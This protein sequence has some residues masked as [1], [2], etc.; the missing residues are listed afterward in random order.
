VVAFGTI[1][2]RFPFT[3]LSGAKRRPALVVSRDNDRRPD[4]VVCF[5]SVP[6]TGP[7]MAPLAP[8]AGTGL[9]VPSVV[10][11]DQLATLDPSAIAGSW[12]RRR[13]TGFG[14][15]RGLPRCVR[16][17]P[18]LVDRRPGRWA[19][20]AK[21]PLNPAPP[22]MFDYEQPLRPAT[23]SAL[24]AALAEAAAAIARLDEALAFHPLQP[25]L[26]HRAR[27]DAV[28]RQAAVDGQAIDPWH[29]ATIVEGLRL[30]LD[31]ALRIAERGAVLDAARHALSLHQW[32]TAPEFDEEGEVQ[33]AERHLAGFAGRGETPLLAAAHG[34][35]AWLN[36]GG[37]SGAGG[38]ARPPIR[39]ALVRFWTRHRVL[40]APVP[41]AG[42]G[43]LRPEMPWALSAWMPAFLRALAAEADD[44]RQMLRD[45][46]R[47]W[48][49]ARAAAAG[50]RRDSHAAAAVDVL[51]AMPLISATSLAAAVGIAVKNAIGL[52]DSLVAAGAAVEVT[53]RAK[54][55]LFGLRGMAPLAEAVR[56][57]YRP[58]PGRGRGRP[59]AIR[60]EPEPSA[61]PLPPLSPIE[62]RNFDCTD[63]ERS[64]AELDQV[65]RR[66]RRALDALAGRQ[67]QGA[68][69]PD[70]RD[71]IAPATDVR[72]EPL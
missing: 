9:K 54:R 63:L 39:A 58:E 14:A 53:R 13:P 28:R 35:H 49:A 50:R 20:R 29:L 43:A 42:A 3:D 32:L 52:L 1:V 37:L 5:T 12:A 56:P 41:L 8:T 71:G 64:L 46:E 60:E 55:R 51:A 33:L 26:L 15:A 6:R 34:V 36:G 65:M 24:P 30:R 31:G 68:P 40:R 69:P 19:I 47:A 66:T 2:L 4:R 38:G 48:F 62:R 21:A 72:L 59:M 16:L 27:L 18:A 25:A 70:Q 44:W 7:D 45:L 23:E 10:R 17:R 67:H 11:F 61:G 57:P 22:R